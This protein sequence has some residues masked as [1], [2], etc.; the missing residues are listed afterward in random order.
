MASAFAPLLASPPFLLLATGSLLGASLPLARAGAEVGWR[1]VSFVFATA[2]TAGLLLLILHAR[3]LVRRPGLLTYS[4]ICG[5]LSIAVPNTLTFAVMPH[6][7][8]GFAAMLYT[9]PPLLTYL[10]AGVCRVERFHA[11]RLV[12]IL[13]GLGGAVLLALTRGAAADVAG[14]WLLLALGVPVSIAAGNVYRKLR[15]PEGVNAGVLAG[16]M[17]LGGAASL[18]PL[19]FGTSPFWPG[20]TEA[21]LLALGQCLLTS[22]TFVVYFRFQRV[23]DPVYFSQ[24]GYV[25][26]AVGIFAGILLFDERLSLGLA[27]GMGLI[28]LGITL[29]NRAP[30]KH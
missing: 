8:T 16:G 26:S 3:H 25:I 14:I 5:V 1:P 18:A 4:L 19:V 2:I 28:A 24:M 7:G 21:G 13:V 29:V 17:L 27:A 23:A 22:L 9:L 10:F 30:H 15:L 6:L 12:G 20:T 11:L